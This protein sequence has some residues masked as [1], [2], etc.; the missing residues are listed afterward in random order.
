MFLKNC[1]SSVNTAFQNIIR[2][3]R[4]TSFTSTALR[5]NAE[6]FGIDL[7]FRGIE[8]HKSIRQG[9][10]YHHSL[11]LIFNIL[12]AAHSSFQINETLHHF[13]LTAVLGLAVAATIRIGV[14]CGRICGGRVGATMHGRTAGL[15]QHRCNGGIFDVLE[16]VG[17]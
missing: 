9:E 10:R 4:K 17:F 11:R 12:R 8:A 6:D 1:L 13:P 14:G 3:D 7:Q 15:A 16:V 5:S 2:L